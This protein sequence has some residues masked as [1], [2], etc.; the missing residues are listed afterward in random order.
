MSIA[1]SAFKAADAEHDFLIDSHFRIAAVEIRGNHPVRRRIAR[2]IRIQ[3]IQFY[4]SDIRAPNL[5]LHASSGI[6]HA[7]RQ[8]P[9]AFFA[10][11]LD[12]HIVKIVLNILFLLP[13]VGIEVLAEIAVLIQKADAHYRYPQVGCGLKMVARQNAKAAGVNRQAIRECRIPR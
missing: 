13:A 11:Q 6:L 5:C 2:N 12:R 8:R 9:L 3:Q 10:D 4:P 7:D 1:S